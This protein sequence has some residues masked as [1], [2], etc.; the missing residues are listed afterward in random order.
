[1]ADIQRLPKIEEVEREASA[2]IARLDADD[3]SG[4][5]RARFGAWLQS[6][7]LH[8]RTY[9]VLMGTWRQF[10]AAAPLIHHEVAVK[11][12]ALRLRYVQDPDAVV[13]QAAVNVTDSLR[14]Q[15]DGTAQF[16]SV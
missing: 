6:H 13:H 11:A 9:R 5:D 10:R 15:G 7:P 3:V 12:A 14:I 4:E 1:M 16:D 2:W 8:A